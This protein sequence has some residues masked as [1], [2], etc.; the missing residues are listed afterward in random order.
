MAGISRRK[1]F[2]QTNELS[3]KEE[4]ANKPSR[5]GSDI[6]S[7]LMGDHNEVNARAQHLNANLEKYYPEWNE[8]NL[9]SNRQAETERVKAEKLVQE[10]KE[11]ISDVKQRVKQ[12]HKEVQVRFRQRVGD[13]GF[14]K[15]EL[16]N[17]LTTLKSLLD[18]M[19]SQSIRL[20]QALQAC[21][22]PLKVNDQ[23][24]AFRRQRQGVDNVR[25]N[26]ERH[27]EFELQTVQS[28][29]VLLKQTHMQVDEDMRQIRRAKN[30]IEK[31]L[32]DK[33]VALNI[34]ESTSTLEMTGPSK[35]NKPEPLKRYPIKKKTEVTTYT[36]SDWQSLCQKNLEMADLRVQ[37]TLSL[38]STVDGILAH[39]ASH[40][41]SQKDLTDR[42]FERRLNEVKGAKN[43]LEQQLSE[44]IVK[45]HELEESV[46]ALDKALSAKHGPLATCQIR[47]QKRKQRP[48]RELVLDDVDLQL[49]MESENL[50]ESIR[51]LET[52]LS[53]SR[54]CYAALQKSRLDLEAQI[55]V[56]NQSIF[57]DEV[58]CVTLRQGVVIQPY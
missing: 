44:T 42:A 56:K 16:D 5:V 47:I 31:D 20:G 21:D 23:C 17:R 7:S 34:D 36:P 3:R 22:L 57:I 53:R 18:E 12:D 29:Q 33:E 54:D 10:T 32:A 24:L 38:Q 45:I 4:M 40:L 49:Q 13:I 50:I 39:V 46:E 25:D 58:K 19:D 26:V 35:T 28:A 8:T 48:E 43:L 9:Q 15:S 14:W 37:N 11:L 41:R 6:S 2:P 55:N 1:N 52:Q 27:L 30:I 51:R